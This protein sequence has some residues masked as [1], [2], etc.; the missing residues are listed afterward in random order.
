MFNPIQDHFYKHTFQHLVENMQD[1]GADAVAV[2]IRV[3][4]GAPPGATHF[5]VL[6]I[7]VRKPGALDEKKA[8]V[9]ALQM[10]CG[11]WLYQHVPPPRNWFLRVLWHFCGRR[12]RSI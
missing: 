5:Q 2:F 10:E 9:I 4:R 8:L 3:P 12:F 11:R 1:L 7:G 6:S